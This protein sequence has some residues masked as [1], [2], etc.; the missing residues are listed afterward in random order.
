MS[1]EVRI[2]VE[3][4]LLAALK[5]KPVHLVDVIEQAIERTVGRE[6]MNPC[7]IRCEPFGVDMLGS[8]KEEL[9]DL[10]A[11]KTWF[12]RMG[13]DYDI[14]PTATGGCDLLAL[15]HTF[16]FDSAGKLIEKCFTD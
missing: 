1:I 4:Q 10:V 13:I 14:R 2:Q 6:N 9:T 8:D 15:M 5:E 7:L 11:T 3:P 16:T 12:D